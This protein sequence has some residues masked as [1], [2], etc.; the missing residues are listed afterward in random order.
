M[1]PPA[2]GSRRYDSPHRREQAAATRRAVL[3]AAERL[4]HEQGFAATTMPAIAAKAG[5]AVKTV[6]LAL[7]TKS[8]VIHAL[9]DLR[10][11]GDDQPIPVP[12]RPWYLALLDEP[13]PVLI[14][15]R[16]AD[17][18]ALVKHRAGAVLQIVRDAAGADPDVARLWA[19]IQGEF[20]QVLVPVVA[21]L[22]DLG[23]LAGHLDVAEATDIL[24]ALNHPD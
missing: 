21:R 14:L 20:H 9:W 23:A 8:D 6:Y 24:W 2:K 7:G 10:L 18:S 15:Q 13:D 16:L 1:A 3:E 11:G 22:H 19:T 5:V 12:E 4:F 17:R